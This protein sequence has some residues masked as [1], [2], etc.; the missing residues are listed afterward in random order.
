MC[1]DELFY[2]QESVFDVAES[3]LRLRGALK[4]MGIPVFATF[5]HGKN[6]EE[7]GMSMGT[8]GGDGV[9][10]A[11]CRDEIDAGQ[12]GDLSGIAP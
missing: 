11:V 1:D 12:S 9:R 4:K 3:V 10:L 5:D 6:A 7:A 2:T 8:G